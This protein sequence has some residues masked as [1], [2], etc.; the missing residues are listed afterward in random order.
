MDKA[1]REA[2]RLFSD[3]SETICME[4]KDIALIP[5]PTEL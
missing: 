2:S 5:F 4:A 1:G 3:E